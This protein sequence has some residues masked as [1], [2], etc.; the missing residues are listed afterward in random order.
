[1]TEQITGTIT[2]LDLERRIAFLRVSEQKRRTELYFGPELSQRIRNCFG[3]VV[4]LSGQW[5]YET[6]DVWK[7]GK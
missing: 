6:F 4:T 7:I 5:I 1:M 2:A 3:A